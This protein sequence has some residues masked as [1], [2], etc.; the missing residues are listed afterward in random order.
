MSS[1]A[2]QTTLGPLAARIN[3]EGPPVVLL[4][5]NGEDAS[6]FDAMGPGLAGLTTIAL[7]SRG[8]GASP[9]GD[10]RLTLAQLGADTAQALL[11]YRRRYGYQGRFGVIGFSD[12]ANVALEVALH[13]PDLLAGQVLMGGNTRPGA[14]KLW[15]HLSL[16]VGHFVLGVAGLFSRKANHRRKIWGLMIGQPLVTEAQLKSVSVPTLVLAGERDVVARRVSLRV[17]QTIPGAEWAEIQ[18]VGHLVPLKCPGVA[19]AL[20]VDFLRR[21]LDIK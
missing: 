17:A 16:W 8:H 13:R 15:V 18:G 7:D 5:G 4:H 2:V 14:T 6:L 19:A 9:L 10:K 3:G 20:S 1:S 21:Y 12:G 11:E